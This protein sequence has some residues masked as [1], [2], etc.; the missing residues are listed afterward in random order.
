[1]GGSF[2][3]CGLIAWHRRP[4]SHGGA[5]MMATGFG[6]LLYPLLAQIDVPLAATVA[7]FV[8]DIW[9]FAFLP[10]VL[11]N[12]SG[13]RLQSRVDW[14]L[15]AAFALPL[16]VLQFVWLLLLEQEGNVLGLFPDAGRRRR[17]RQGPA[18]A[19]RGR[20][21][22]DRRRARD[23]LAGRVAA[24][25][26]RDAAQH[27]RRASRCCMFTSLLVND[28]VTGKRSETLLWIALASLITVPAAFLFGLL[29]SR[30]ARHGLAELLLGMRTLRG[31]AAAA[32]ALARRSATSRSRSPTAPA[33]A[34]RPRPR[35]RTPVERDGRVMATLVYDAALDDDPELV[36]AVGAAAA[37][38]LENERL[39]AESEAR[40]EELRASRERLVAAGDEERRRLERNL[41]DGAQQRLVALSL[42]L[43]MIQGRIRRDPA[44][45][46]HLVDA[47]S[48]ELAQS[49]S[50]LRELARGIHPAV[51]NHGLPAALEALADRSPVPTIV[52]CDEPGAPARGRRA[53][54]LLRRLRGAR[55]HRQ[56]LAGRARL[57][58]ADAHRR[59]GRDPDRR[60]RDRRRR[61]A[62]R[63]RP[64]RAR[65]PRRGALR[66]ALR[67][68]PAGRRDGRHRGAARRLAC[69]A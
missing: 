7:M 26:A 8:S 11:T 25:A 62:G 44:E 61:R 60:R 47:A 19:V 15:I 3:A 16:L 12:L 67:H 45:A 49:L 35:A 24:A 22:G 65:R 59:R 63:I 38:A 10:L 20:R 33:V 48:D 43:R 40:L 28:L 34:R 23:P 9:I 30:L 53:R 2:A 56:V 29:R 69:G 68:Q 42:Q 54:R 21:R 46:E 66:A 5:L 51:L 36:E 39:H 17:G 50:E 37:I 52:E 4:D 55:E 41:H 18:G 58:P 14:L 27:R 13:G 57:G 64:A 6:F 1:M 31:E 32:R